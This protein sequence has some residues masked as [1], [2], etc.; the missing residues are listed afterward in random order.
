MQ[1]AE[2]IDGDPVAVAAT[3]FDPYGQIVKML[4]PRALSIAIY[5]RMGL[6]IWLNAGLDSPELHRLLQH[7]LT[8]ELRPGSQEEG[9]AELVDRDHC[10]YVFLLR[11][12]D[13]QLLGAV[14]TVIREAGRSGAPRP[15]ELV[16]GLLRPVLECLRREL[17]A[18]YSIG[19]LQRSLNLRDRDLELLLG[20]T[21]DSPAQGDS[22]DDLAQ[23][24]ASRFGRV[25]EIVVDKCGFC[26]AGK[27]A[28]LKTA[29]GDR[30]KYAGDHKQRCN[31]CKQQRIT[32]FSHSWS[33]QK[34]GF[35]D[36]LHLL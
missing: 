26:P 4:M 8:E 22:A 17:V 34:F 20:A 11:D 14:G 3:S 7:S 27:I 30:G 1:L 9:F 31:Q 21:P 19:D 25:I 2:A 16:Q 15:F 13:Q 24:G 32:D 28:A 23:V 12:A 35:P 33:F 29:I 6:P 10:A 36:R 18:Q 5:D